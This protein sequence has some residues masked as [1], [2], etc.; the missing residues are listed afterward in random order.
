MSY[1]YY[2]YIYVYIYNIIFIYIYI[3]AHRCVH[4]L[5]CIEIF[6]VTLGYIAFHHIT[7][8][9]HIW[10]H[11]PTKAWIYPHLCAFAVLGTPKYM[12]ISI[13]IS[14]Y[15]PTYCILHILSYPLYTQPVQLLLY[16]SWLL[17]VR[18]P[19]PLEP[20]WNPQLLAGHIS[21]C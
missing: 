11:R 21:K 7:Q 9:R 1:V 17:S 6:Y 20:T 14:T 2:M 8:H 5:H 18:N 13:H 12:H 4:A 15:M 19:F 16:A 10:L 3:R